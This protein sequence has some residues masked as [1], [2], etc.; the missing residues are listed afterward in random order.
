M[1]EGKIKTMEEE[2]EKKNQAFS[3][4]KLLF[5]EATENNHSLRQENEQLKQKVF[6][7]QN[8]PHLLPYKCVSQDKILLFLL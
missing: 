2:L 8:Q 4:L 6:H 7:R 5:R 1:Y 3:E